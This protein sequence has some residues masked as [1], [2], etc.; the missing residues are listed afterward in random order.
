MAEKV[1]SSQRKKFFALAIFLLVFFFGLIW[2]VVVPTGEGPD[3]KQHVS[4]INFLRQQKRIPVFDQEENLIKTTYVPQLWTEKFRTGAYYSQ[5][6]NSPLSYL[7]FLSLSSDKSSAEAK[8][9]MRIASG[10]FIAL[11]AVFLFLALANFQPKKI[12]A[13]AIITIFITLVPQVIFSAGYVNIEPIGLFFSALAFYFLTLIISG[14]NQPVNY[15]FLG[16]ALGLLALCKAN[17]LALVIF[18][19]FI[20]LAKIYLSKNSLKQ[21]I[22]NLAVIAVP[23][24]TLNAWWWTRNIR[25]YG[26]PIITNYIGKKV[27]ASGP[28]WFLPPVKAGYNIFTIIWQPDF[29]Q[30]T[31][32]GFFAALGKLD[33]FLPTIFY[34]LFFLISVMLFFS[35]ALAKKNRVLVFL[36]LLLFVANFLI[37][38]NKN[39]V[40]FSPQGRH[41]FPMLVPLAWIFYLGAAK[42]KNI[43]VKILIFGFSVSAAIWSLAVVYFKYKAQ[44]ASLHE[45]AGPFSIPLLFVYTIIAAIVFVILAINLFKIR[46]ND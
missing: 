27:A 28:E 12:S 41:L 18:F 34:I 20:A 17:F 6:F 9:P 35:A 2:A 45:N 23:A 39:L 42:I 19:A 36:V 7:P 26:D 43:V 3:E 14:K 10:F 4:M 11:F 31:F 21:K 32:L 5:A 38:A 37:F 25:L 30:N 1:N 16:L 46:N 8:S 44:G 22:Y 40:D 33:I 13:A 15:L 24:L 29:A